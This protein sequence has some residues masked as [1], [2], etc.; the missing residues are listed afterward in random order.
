MAFFTKVEHSQN[1]IHTAANPF[2]VFG[3]SWVMTLRMDRG[4]C[5]VCPLFLA[6]ETKN[7]QFN[8]TRLVVKKN[9]GQVQ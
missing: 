3:V 4:K 1:S 9:Y 6:H 7:N 5:S 2:F 8:E